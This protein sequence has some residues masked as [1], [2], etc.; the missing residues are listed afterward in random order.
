RRWARRPPRLPPSASDSAYAP[1]SRIAS[2]IPLRGNDVRPTFL[3]LTALPLFAFQSVDAK[4]SVRPRTE[5]HDAH[6]RID[7]SLVVVPAFAT[8]ERGATVLDLKREQFRVFDNDAE[9]QITY[10]AS[11][12]S[13][14]SV[15]V[16]V[17][18]S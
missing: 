14:V 12:D 16:L 4:V 5:D 6:L 13:P 2:F 3:L 7:T 17:D 15:G 11:D 8:T 18:A 9:Q 10:F 1:A